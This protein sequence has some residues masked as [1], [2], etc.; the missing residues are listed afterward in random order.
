MTQVSTVQTGEHKE[1]SGPALLDTIA[2][3]AQKFLHSSNA[4]QVTTA[5]KTLPFQDLA[6]LVPIRA[7]LVLKRSKTVIDVLKAF[8]VWGQVSTTLLF[9]SQM[10]KAMKAF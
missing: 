6:Q 7:A 4:R 5:R 1:L 8:T 3:E 10:A 9:S 2:L